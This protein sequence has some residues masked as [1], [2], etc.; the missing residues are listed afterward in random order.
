[1]Y[2]TPNLISLGRLAV[3]PI[4]AWAIV[5]EHWWISLGLYA[6]AVGT[7]FFDGY[8]ARKSNQVTRL[9]SYIDHFSDCCFVVCALLALSIQ[10]VVPVVLPILIIGAFTQ[11]ILDSGVIQH[12]QLRPSQLGRWNGISYFVLVGVI[13]VNQLANTTILSPLT[14]QI[15]GWILCVT[16]VVSMGE[17]LRVFLRQR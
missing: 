6:F 2:S 12:Q 8:L 14:V 11:Y 4:I 13:L 5:D 10:E 7:D 9:G 17:R 15:V 16:T 3:A 1:M